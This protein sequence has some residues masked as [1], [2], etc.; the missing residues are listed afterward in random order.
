MASESEHKSTALVTESRWVISEDFRSV[1]RFRADC[2]RELEKPRGL[3]EP[4]LLNGRGSARPLVLAAADRAL[5]TAPRGRRV[6]YSQPGV[7]WVNHPLG[8]SGSGEIP[9]AE[10]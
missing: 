6:S 5:A 2:L 4:G 10:T 7:R 9:E 8:F 1:T 3:A